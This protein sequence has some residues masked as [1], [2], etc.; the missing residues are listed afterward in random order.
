MSLL[1]STY[2]TPA[3]SSLNPY[4]GILTS[5]SSRCQNFSH[6]LQRHRVHTVA[7][8]SSPRPRTASSAR[9]SPPPP[10][11]ALSRSSSVIGI[12]PPPSR[13]PPLPSSSALLGPSRPAVTA[14]PEKHA[15][16][17]G[18]TTPESTPLDRHHR[19][20]EL[21]HPPGHNL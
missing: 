18:V 16:L 10:G 1:W 14:A 19:A 2:K 13:P 9:P 3:A 5:M 17:P 11:T 20:R 12:T 7:S 4:R 21:H 15:I 6:P 8:T